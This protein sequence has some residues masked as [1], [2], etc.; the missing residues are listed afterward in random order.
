MATEPAGREAEMKQGGEKRAG[1]VTAP[2]M[3][4][5]VAAALRISGAS[6]GDLH[7]AIM[8]EGR[9]AFAQANGS[10][11]GTAKIGLA[12]L[13]TSGLLTGHEVRGLGHICGL[14]FALAHNKRTIE[15][16][17][18]KVRDYYHE[19]VTSGEASPTA[20]V[21]ASIMM[22]SSITMLLDNS[23]KPSAPS[24]QT[25][26][27]AASGNTG[28]S[29]VGADVGGAIGGAVGGGLIGGGIGAGV[30]GVFGAI[31]GSLGAFIGSRKNDKG[32]DD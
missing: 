18:P 2:K 22:D 24:G 1:D 25:M 31:G 29:I 4:I 17:C 10:A 5:P 32:D 11:L 19:L 30:G 21:L 12:R 3:E 8:R 27:A 16:V 26:A 13:Q 9:L 15:E 20:L 6:A 14:I 7:G 28:G 23:S